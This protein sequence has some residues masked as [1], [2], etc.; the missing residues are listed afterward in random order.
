M[1]IASLQDELGYEG[2]RHSASGL[3]KQTV[4]EW[5]DSVNY[6]A[7]NDGHYQPSPFALKFANFVKLANAGTGDSHP[8]PVVH[9]KML[10]L[11]PGNRKRV[12]NLCARGLAKTTLF[13][14]Y[15][16]LYL[17][18]FNEIDGFGEI[19]AMIY[20]SDSMENGV[21]SARKNIEYRYENSDF[22]K[23][24]IPEAK[25]TDNYLEFRNKEGKRL[26]V[27]M[28]GAQTGLRGTKIFGK[29]PVLC[30]LDDLVSDADAKSKAAMEAIKD[31]V[32][33]GVDFAL[34]PTR[35]KIVFNGT[36]YN[37]NDILY[38][39][40]ESGAWHVNVWP[41][42]E[43]FPCTREEFRGAW[44]ERFSYDFVQEQYNA[45][46]DTKKMPA[47]MQELMLRITS[48]EEKLVPDG[49]IRFYS[50][51]KLLQRRSQFNFYITTDFATS[52]KEHADDSVISVWAYGAA[53]N[54]FWVDGVAERMTMDK[55]MEHLF[56]LSQ[57]YNPMGV[58]IEVTGQQ[59]GF[60]PWIQE[61]MI[62]TN[63]WFNLA[64]HG[65]G[66]KPG[67]RSQGSKLTRFNGV[68]PMIRAGLVAYPSE[69]ENHPVVRK[70][71]E[72]M[73]MATPQ[74][75]KSKH[76]DC[77]DTVSQLVLLN[78]WRPSGAEAAAGEEGVADSFW[79]D[80]EEEA[81]R[82]MGSYVV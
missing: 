53:G 9:L 77:V 75:F 55:T 66:G 74:G 22:L 70:H 59:G 54:W 31:T 14:E 27:K 17:A 44:E 5:L 72:Q 4:D 40:V 8:T 11:L 52:E 79:D 45:A 68:L 6:A 12:A 18:V 69:M 62:D 15:L 1:D 39:A 26:G 48:E 58:G 32:Y 36:P 30:V 51:T 38:E 19:D 29:R 42:C 76:D 35:R 37:K 33:K 41:V 71:L 64:S 65:N 67:I 13:F 16:V 10:D 3:V 21:K 23:H 60:I 57:M 2:Q 46:L 78:A 28:F 80:P 61:R 50:R 34:D 43:R 20:I 81:P 7:L 47:F 25:F 82:G 56:R 73:A 63:V 49:C 24:W